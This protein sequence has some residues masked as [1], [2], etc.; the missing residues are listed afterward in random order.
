M[1]IRELLSLRRVL[2][3]QTYSGWEDAISRATGGFLLEGVDVVA[4][5]IEALIR[6]ERL[7]PTGLP[8]SPVGVAIP[9]ADPEY[10][11]Q[12]FLGIV[13]LTSPILFREMGDPES[14]VWV[15]V[16]I[17]VGLTNEK[18]SE[19]TNVLS[20]L[21]EIFEDEQVLREIY[22]ANNP[23]TILSILEEK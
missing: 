13:T 20:R 21:V 10:V 8:T 2:V 7:F 14:Q 4:G 23:E 11:I 22:D 1:K 16:M 12:P 5:Y 19:Q 6:R 9:H 15:S 3:H 17:V 18:S